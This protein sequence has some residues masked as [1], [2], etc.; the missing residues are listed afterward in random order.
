[1]AHRPVRLQPTVQEVRA[2]RGRRT[3]NV[4]GSVRGLS[5]GGAVSDLPGRSGWCNFLHVIPGGARARVRRG[6]GGCG[7]PGGLAA[8]GRVV[9]GEAPS[10]P[11]LPRHRRAT[12]STRPPPLVVPWSR[13]ERLAAGGPTAPC[14][15][16]RPGRGPG[17][18][19]HRPWCPDPGLGARP[20]SK[21]GGEACPARRGRARPARQRRPDLARRL[22]VPGER[23]GSR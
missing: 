23:G 22:V 14:S 16:H 15:L 4:P 3:T 18:R 1:M 9:V 7:G 21:T 20:G 12:S 10:R 8:L 19:C 13:A 11:P 17:R 6:G 2:P 5:L